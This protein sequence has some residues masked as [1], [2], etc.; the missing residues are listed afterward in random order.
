L[1]FV[2]LASAFCVC[3]SSAKQQVAAPK[4]LSLQEF[5]AEIGSHV[6]QPRFA[7]ASWGIKIVS[8]D[9]G[10]TLFETNAH[11]LLKPASNAKLYTAALALDALGLD[12]RIR[13]SIYSR[14]RP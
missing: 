10:A 9:S 2:F 11:K 8:L 5:Q 7:S 6:G 14:S 4:D 13:T 12:Y 1:C 3:F